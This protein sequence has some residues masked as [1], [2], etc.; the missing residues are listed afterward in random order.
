MDMTARPDGETTVLIVDDDDILRTLMRAALRHEGFRVIECADGSEALERCVVERPDL[1]I[2]D[3]AMPVMDGF[4]LCR[5]LRRDPA[6][7]H[8]PILM[9]TGLD[10]S[11]SITKAY[12]SGAT[13]FIAKPL[14]LTVLTHR[15]RYMLRAASVFAEL[16]QNE[17][18]LAVAKEVA[19]KA[20]EAKT[21]F[22]AIVSHELRTPLNAIIGFA[23]VMRDSLMGPLPD[24]YVTYPQVIAESGE[25]L[26]DIIN[27]VLDVARAESNRLTL[28]EE[29]VDPSKVAAFV[30]TMFDETTRVAGLAFSVDADDRLPPF[31]ADLH[32]I[33]QVLINLVSNAVKFSAEGG[34]VTV[35]LTIGPGGQPT[36]EVA[37]NG[38]GMTADEIA[39]AMTPFGQVDASLSRK[40]G[41]LGLGLP[42]CKHLVELH[43]GAL[44]IDSDLGR[45][46]TVRVTLPAGRVVAS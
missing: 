7:Q 39:T 20:N 35:R 18:T 31:H 14:N 32:K 13:D 10:D 3:V 22:L 11:A 25:H 2:S 5:R 28:D 27:S 9:A 8:L 41:G 36:F 4:E 17:R 38:I 29:R 45:G 46:T 24:A 26:L 42:I 1:L 33:Q 6:T 21:N 44:T 19:E 15:V 40:H 23:S 34:R 30:H 43:G 12:D 16:Q 37:D